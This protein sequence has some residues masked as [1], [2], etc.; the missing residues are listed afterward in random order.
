MTLTSDKPTQ[1]AKVP[2][3][4]AVEPPLEAVSPVPPPTNPQA[5][6]WW[7]R[8]GLRTK[9]TLLALVIGVTPVLTLGTVQFFRTSD[10]ARQTLFQQDE[11]LSQVVA[12][13]LSRFMLERYG[14]IQVLAA[15]PILSNPR[16]ISSTSADEKERMLEQFMNSYG[17]YDS[18]AVTDADGKRILSVGQ[19]APDSFKDLDYY[20]AIIAT[21]KPSVP[22]PRKSV[23]TGKVSIFLAAPIFNSE[24]GQLIGMVRTRIP[25]KQFVEYL[26][27]DNKTLQSYA[28]YVVN[29]KQ[30]AFVAPTEA[31]L[32]QP[33]AKIFAGVE[34]LLKTETGTLG[35]VNQLTKSRV[36]LS[37]TPVPKA[38]DGPNLDWSILMAQDQAILEAQQRQLFGLYLLGTAATALVV[39][40]FASYLARRTTA[41]IVD[42]A[43]VVQELGSGKL[44]SRLHVSGSDE[45][46]VLGTNINRMAGQIQ[47]LLIS[48]EEAARQQLAVQAEI[49]RQQE[50]NS[51][52]QQ[53]AKEFLQNRALE[54]L[55][56]V[57]PLRQG[58]LTIRA[59][60]TADEIGTIADSYNAT[61]NNLRE[62]INQ[63]Q[64]AASQVDLTAADSATSVQELAQDALQQANVIHAA[65]TNIAEMTTS[66]ATVAQNAQATEQ[67]MQLANQTVQEGD[68]AMN[69]AMEGILTVRETVTE[70]ARKVQQ[71]GASSDKISKVVK[72]IGAF[73]AQTN[74]LALKASIE[75]A[76]AGEEGRG[77]VVLADEVRSLAQQSAQATDEIE[78][79][80][81]SIQTDTREVIVAMERG[82]QQTL[83]GTELLET[84][85]QNLTR[86]I[87]TTEQ[88]SQ[89]VQAIAEATTAQSQTSAVVSETM[90]DVAAIA[91][92]TSNRSTRVQ[93]AFQ[94][95]LTV[96]EDLQ[97]TVGRF[98][99]S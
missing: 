11:T 5:I 69:R 30:K 70:T 53:Q 2:A 38:Q 66:I 68:V 85:R 56:E 47:E 79:L 62:I 65:L 80:V 77:F 64:R 6:H 82:T 18:I 41:P 23:A 17:F 96:A 54:L 81:A 37:H 83:T 58:D 28:V 91:N 94:N 42:A 29:D 16:V 95:L 97:K 60:V 74:L 89:L 15:L 99:L 25:L 98:K 50:E 34:K 4:P 21:R 88:I 67:A 52:Q 61:I 13:N 86:M 22:T 40:L 92:Q 75:A 39:G 3:P 78:Q 36:F 12:D 87:Q 14:D 35:L 43:S 46:A 32:D 10:Q 19:K 33:V 63:V 1:S 48:Q 55:M 27:K 57:A 93:E 7:S 24:T 76:R 26:F 45:I 49:A 51:R 73:A 20:K 72:L 9:A 44:E 90:T 71:L 31:E 84:T 59:K 8:M